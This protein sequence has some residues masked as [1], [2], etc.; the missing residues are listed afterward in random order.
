[1]IS[2]IMGKISFHPTTLIKIMSSLAE[3]VGWQYR[4]TQ[5]AASTFIIIYIRS[6]EIHPGES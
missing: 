3:A 5:I 1:M 4:T 6:D 2:R